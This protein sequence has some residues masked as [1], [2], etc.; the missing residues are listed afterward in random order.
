MNPLWILGCTELQSGLM[1]L[2][3]IGYEA[4]QVAEVESTVQMELVVSGIPQIT[5]MAFLPAKG[6]QVLV[7]QKEGT[8]IWSD[9]D[10]KEVKSLGNFDVRSA[11]EQGLLSVAVHPEYDSNHLIYL[12]M[13]PMDG[14]ARTEISEFQ[15]DLSESMVVKKRVLFEY[16]QPFPNHNG[17]AIRFGR[18]GHLYV[19]LGDGGWRNDPKA[20][21]QNFTTPL[22]GILRLN[23]NGDTVVPADNPYVD[24]PNTHDLLWVT[25]LR[26][27]WKF[28]PL[29]DG[30]VIVADVGQ[31]AWEEITVAQSGDNLGWNVWEGEAC[32]LG[33]DQSCS[34]ED[35]KGKAFRAPVHTYGHDVGQSITGGVVVRGANQYTGQYLFGD[36]MTG[37]IWALSN[38][39]QESSVQE[40]TQVG[41]N[42][43]TF[44][45]DQQGNVYVADFGPGNI[46]QM[47]L[48]K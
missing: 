7:T 34:P 1:S 29:S 19:G 47:Q 2:M 12:H 41:F 13:S 48:P 10:S 9:L 8:L 33:S 25:G 40:L 45:Q 15:L 17:G 3:P 11:S 20:N 43:S 6:R 36:F 46:Y 21:G 4:P 23:V 24:D 39:D 16:E 22:G 32:L 27:P 38:W 26:N 5:D 18:D 30:R 31:N 42:I 28:S 35:V 37:Y 14:V 44:G